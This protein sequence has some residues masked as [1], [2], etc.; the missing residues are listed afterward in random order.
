MRYLRW[1]TSINRLNQDLQ[2]YVYNTGTIS[3]KLRRQESALD[4]QKGRQLKC[5]ESEFPP[6]D[7][8]G[9]YFFRESTREINT[10]GSREIATNGKQ[11]SYF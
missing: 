6:T 2:D 8:R 4:L 10:Y 5:R 3:G 9:G 7:R 11:K 1:N